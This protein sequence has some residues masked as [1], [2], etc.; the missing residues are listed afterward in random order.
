M[1]KYKKYDERNL[2]DAFEHI[3]TRLVKKLYK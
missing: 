1:T 3:A 2:G